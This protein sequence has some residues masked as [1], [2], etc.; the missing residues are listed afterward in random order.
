M[1]IQSKIEVLSIKKFSLIKN[2]KKFLNNNFSEREISYC[3]KKSNSDISFIGKLCSKNALK[4]LIGKKFKKRDIEILNTKKGRPY[5]YIKGRRMG[6]I[7]CSISHTGENAV[8]L[9]VIK[10]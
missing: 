4:K 3:N 5:V 2:K 9:I 10:R 6:N 8:A 1:V 7:Y